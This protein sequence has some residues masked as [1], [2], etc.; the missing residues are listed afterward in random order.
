MASNTNRFDP[1][2]RTLIYQQ[3]RSVIHR[4]RVEKEEINWVLN[5]LP[6]DCD[7]ALGLRYRLMCKKVGVPIDWSTVNQHMNNN[8]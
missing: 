3:A 1:E 5:A 4:K 6:L 8:F 2:Y 7:R